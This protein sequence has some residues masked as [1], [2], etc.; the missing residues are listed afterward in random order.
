[1]TLLPIVLIVIASFTDEKALLANG[2]SF[3]PK[4]WS[5]DA[6]YYMI[7]QGTTILRAYGVTIFVTVVDRKS[8]V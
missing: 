6:Y 3:F 4:G 7:K 1:M 5:L 2:Y 8:V